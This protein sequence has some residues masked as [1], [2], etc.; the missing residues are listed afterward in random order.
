MLV[1]LVIQV[2][3]GLVADDDIYVT[4]PLRKFVSSEFS[5]WATGLHSLNADI[6]LALIAVH[7]AAILAYLLLEGRNLT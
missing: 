4:E 3:T 1:S 2:G 5:N 6:L 7:V